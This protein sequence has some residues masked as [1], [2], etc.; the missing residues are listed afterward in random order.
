MKIIINGSFDI[1]HLGHL[2]LFKKGRS[3]ENSYVLVLVDSD[4]LIASRKGPSRPINNLTERVE[5]LRA[6]KYIDEVKVFH[7]QEEL[8]Q[9][10]KDF[11]PDVML[12]GSDYKDYNNVGQ[13]YCRKVIFIE[14]DNYSTTQKIQDITNR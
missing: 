4:E 10:I 9:M 13:E 12:K 2:R 3:F 11:D 6:I 5:L 7:S 1:L 14:R 8:A